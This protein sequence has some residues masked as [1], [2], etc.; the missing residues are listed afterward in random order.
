MTAEELKAALTT[1]RLTPSEAE[2]HVGLLRGSIDRMLGGSKPVPE[3]VAFLLTAWVQHL[4]SRFG[5]QHR[6]SDFVS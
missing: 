2:D 6:D 4:P 3:R 5:F 1:L